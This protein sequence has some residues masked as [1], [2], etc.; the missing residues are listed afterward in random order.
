MSQPFTANW[1]NAPSQAMAARKDLSGLKDDPSFW[2]S[3]I[4]LVAH[5]QNPQ[6]ARR[7]I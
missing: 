3:G 7:C 6:R 4:S 5:M 1:V 2:A